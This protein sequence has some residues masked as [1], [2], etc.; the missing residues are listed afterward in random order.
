MQLRS[1]NSGYTGHCIQCFSPC[2][3]GTNLPQNIQKLGDSCFYGIGATKFTVPETVTTIE[4]WCIARARLTNIIF[5]G[6]APAIGE[7]AFNKITLTAYY[8][9]AKS[10]WTSAMMQNYGGTVTWKAQ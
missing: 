10:G 5:K 8:N 6:D 2:D 9:S 1:R 3:S 4:A 7:G